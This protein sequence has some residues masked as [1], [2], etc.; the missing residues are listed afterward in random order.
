MKMA[1]LRRDE[2]NQVFLSDGG[3]MANVVHPPFFVLLGEN[4]EAIAV[5]D[6]TNRDA[7]E[8]LIAR[9]RAIAIEDR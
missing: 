1:P 8:E 6:G 7:V 2:E 4:A 9:V 3:K 5:Y